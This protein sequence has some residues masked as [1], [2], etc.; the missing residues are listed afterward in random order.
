M[1]VGS[2][3]VSMP[4]T[5]ISTFAASRYFDIDRLSNTKVE[6]SDRQEISLRA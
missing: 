3:A 4:K 5:L 6:V 2:A 1:F